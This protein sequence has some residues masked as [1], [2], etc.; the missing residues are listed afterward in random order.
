MPATG[1]A[2]SSD[3]HALDL[4][5]VPG[6]LLAFVR[7]DLTTH[8]RILIMEPSGRGLRQ[9][10]PDRPEADEWS[11]TWS[12]DGTQLCFA[13]R[14]NAHSHLRLIGA[15]GSRLRDLTCDGAD[16]DDPA[17][18]PD[19]RAIAFSRG[20]QEGPDAIFR[21][22]LHT[23]ELARLTPC[24]W[25][26]STPTWSPDGRR[27]VFR[28]AFGHPAGLHV[29]LADGGDARFLVPGHD[30][31]W[32]AAT[33][34]LAFVHA[35]SVWV[36]PLTPQG[37]AAGDPRPLTRAIGFVDSG[38]SWG[39]DGRHLAFAREFA[40]EGPGIHRLLVMDADSGECSEI[41][42]GREPEWSP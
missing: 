28:R 21:L 13:C 22:D 41:G 34:Q 42:E 9:L 38:P 3:P 11:P 19:G 5:Q 33:S 30:P 15:D 32:S 20:N 25:L 16:D 26:D 10:T 7:G 23:G 14:S 39:P 37:A 8:S 27:L 24:R 35:D 29:M 31:A 40:H 2:A 36:M 1:H 17:W 18:S 12:P 6:G 4:P